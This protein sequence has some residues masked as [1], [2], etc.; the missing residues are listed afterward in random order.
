M[1]HSPVDPVALRCINRAG[2]SAQYL[3]A[4]FVL[5]RVLSAF[6]NAR[7]KCCMY[8][9]VEIENTILGGNHHFFSDIL[10][11]RGTSLKCG[12]WLT[13][14]SVGLFGPRSE[15]ISKRLLPI[16]VFKSGLSFF[17][18]RRQWCPGG[19]QNNLYSIFNASFPGR[20][21]GFLCCPGFC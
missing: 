5:W 3:P 9:H 14:F 7:E 15:F 6:W 4:L 1:V 16:W 19:E 18:L 13:V 8:S 2:F 20:R 12:V 17:P 11:T 10:G 21:L